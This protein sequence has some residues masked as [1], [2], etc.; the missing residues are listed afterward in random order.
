ME[1]LKS[2]Q[3]FLNTS[4]SFHSIYATTE[5]IDNL[6]KLA[7]NIKLFEVNNAEINK[8][9][10]LQNPQGILA[11][12]HQPNNTK[13]EPNVYSNQLN[14]VLDGIQDPGNLGTIIRTADWFG[15]NNIICSL[16]TAD[17]F[18][19]KTVQAS[20]GSLSRIKVYY[21]NIAE[22]LKDK[23]WVGG[24]F[25][26]GDNIYKMNW[27]ENGFIVLGNE[28]QGISQA[29]EKTITQKITIPGFGITESLN[30]GISTAL[31]CSEIRRVAL[32][33]K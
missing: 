2:I 14:L 29:V 32:I 16:D 27:P 17:A 20:M 26:N 30:V 8:I 23:P 11:I 9:S 21:T 31:F 10:T 24:A 13:L 18:N 6:P 1:G 3:D 33:K 22:F 28:G 15:F 19:P 7:T 25:L 5:L 4:F 12:L